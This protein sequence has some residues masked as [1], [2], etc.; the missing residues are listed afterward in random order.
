MKHP[1]S[2]AAL[3]ALAAAS[4]LSVAVAPAQAR[5]A[6]AATPAAPA[7]SGTAAPSQ[8]PKMKACNVAAKGK[9]GDERR[10]F[11]KECLSARK[12]DAAKAPA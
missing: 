12:P 5:T 9:H 6:T 1:L 2:S 8:Q 3:L 7:A 11:M 4:A 10:A